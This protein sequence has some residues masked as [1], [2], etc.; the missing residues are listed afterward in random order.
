[1]LLGIETCLTK[2][3]IGTDGAGAA[4]TGAVRTVAAVSSARRRK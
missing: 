4:I 2:V 1:M 3:A